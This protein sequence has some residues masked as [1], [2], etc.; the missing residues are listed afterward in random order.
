[1]SRKRSPEGC[2]CNETQ[3]VQRITRAVSKFVLWDDLNFSSDMV[4]GDEINVI[5]SGYTSHGLT[6]AISIPQWIEDH[7]D[8]LRTRYL[9]WV[10]ELGETLIDGE[11]LIDLLEI[12]QGFSYWWMTP[13]AEKCNFAKSP[14]ITNIIRLFSLEKIL[15]KQTVES[16][17]L[18]TANRPLACCLQNWC[19]RRGIAFTWSQLPPVAQPLSLF[20][21]V[22]NAAPFIIQGLVWLLKYLGQ[23]WPLRGEGTES[24]KSTQGR[25]CFFSYF[26]NLNV[27][28]A[29]EGRFESR[30]WTSLPEQLGDE[31]VPTNWLH[32]YVP[33]ASMPTAKDASEVLRSLNQKAYGLQ[34]H[35]CLDSFLSLKVIAKTLL[36]MWRIRRSLKGAAS[37][38]SNGCQVYDLW[39]LF[40][41]EWLG[42]MYGHIAINNLLMFNLLEAALGEIPKQSMGV[43]LQENQ[44]W[45]LGLIAA[46][47]TSGHLDL[48]GFPHATVRYWD[49]RYFFDQRLFADRGIN[50]IPLPDKVACNGLGVLDAYKSGGYPEELLCEVESLRYLYLADSDASHGLS[51][52]YKPKR[53]LV[54]GDY[55]RINTQRQLQLLE[56]AVPLLSEDVEIIFKPHPACPIDLAQYPGLAMVTKE[57]ILSELFKVSDLVYSSAVTSAAVD[58]YCYGLPIVS[59]LDGED[60]NLSPLRGF[61][62]VIFVSEPIDLARA[63]MGND[64]L[65]KNRDANGAYFHIDTELPRWKKLL[66]F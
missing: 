2:W 37:I 33:D 23:R 24:W 11:R 34:S 1:L 56:S 14:Q 38:V 35:A 46:W 29:R 49:L 5:W 13:I 12:R 47:R 7:S 42:S 25:V 52:R 6:N 28:E 39:P 9:A 63:I 41:Q 15:E 48:V 30:Y 44:G 32:I 3:C 62:G 26:V 55:L 22:Y 50:S 10:Y 19:K 8:S 16:I 60:L 45:E 66:M 18:V 4:R 61:E 17:R 53:L 36:H 27:S 65:S 59:F 54:V 40:R 64:P 58:G 31:S 57:N 20:K 21:R 51:A 43:Y